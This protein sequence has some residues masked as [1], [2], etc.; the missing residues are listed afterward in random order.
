MKTITA[1]LFACLLT[2]AYAAVMDGTC[3]DANGSFRGEIVFREARITKVGVGI[4]ARAD[5]DRGLYADFPALN[6]Q[7]GRITA[8]ENMPYLAGIGASQE[9]LVMDGG[10]IKLERRVQNSPQG[11]YILYVECTFDV[12]RDREDLARLVRDL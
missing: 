1:I 2:P 5:Y 11:S 8:Q 3:R 7:Q 4:R 10:M 6:L 9:K 12:R